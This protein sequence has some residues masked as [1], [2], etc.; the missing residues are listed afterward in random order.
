MNSKK[1]AERYWLDCLVRAHTSGTPIDSPASLSGEIS[2]DAAYAVQRQLVGKL[3]GPGDR[4]TGWKVGATSRAVM[5]Q[6]DID[7][8]IYGCM[9]SRSAVDGRDGIG[10]SSFC[11]LAVEPEIAIVIDKPLR[12]PGTTEA[13]VMDAA[14]GA[15]AA[16]ELVDCRIKDWKA[17]PAE[18]IA[19]N[20]FHAG[21]ILGPL[22]KGLSGLDLV[23]E[24]VIMRKNGDLLGSA[25][26]VEALGSPLRVV[27]WLADKLSQY[28]LEIGAGQVVSTGSLMP[29]HYV[30]PGDT[31]EVSY[32]A[33]G[34]IQFS[35]GE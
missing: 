31:V 32:G 24:G 9:T 26:G 17:T 16:V 33:L 20:A 15:M 6:L 22:R 7:E 1:K 29:F 25:C 2:L 35:V 27:A 19:D 28:G 18:A 10:L 3:L 23:H 13:D 21:I 11:R 14:A 34:K 5:S 30:A 4:I 8:P 12:G